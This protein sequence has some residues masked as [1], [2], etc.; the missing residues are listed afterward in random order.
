MISPQGKLVREV[1]LPGAH[2]SSLAISPDGKHLI[3]S[4]IED[5]PA[6]GYRGE[7]IEVPNPVAP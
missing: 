3:L 4:S 2:H 6:G 7:L 1:D 5:D